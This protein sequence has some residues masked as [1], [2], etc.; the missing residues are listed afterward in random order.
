MRI[1]ISDSSCLIDLDKGGLLRAI[2]DLPFSFTIPQPL[3]E[4]ELPSISEKGKEVMIEQGMQFAVLT[5]KQVS[6][7]QVY[8]NENRQLALNDCFALVLAEEAEEAILFTA[9]KFLKQIADSK[10]IETHGV[11]WMIDT[12]DEHTDVLKDILLNALMIF[13]RDPLVWLP[14]TEIK[15]RMRRLR[16]K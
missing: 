12:L 3:Y 5:G 15:T 13:E 1:I 4:G 9:D 10:G 14:E 2:F 16:K 7:A 8:Y 11:L 6:Q